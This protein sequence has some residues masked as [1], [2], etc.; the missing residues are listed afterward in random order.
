MIPEA[1]QENNWIATQYLDSGHHLLDSIWILMYPVPSTHSINVWYN[2]SIDLFA[3][4]GHIAVSLL[5]K[6]YTT[7]QTLH[8]MSHSAYCNVSFCKKSIWQQ[9]KTHHHYYINCLL[10]AITNIMIRRCCDCSLIHK[11]RHYTYWVDG[12]HPQSNCTKQSWFKTD[13]YFV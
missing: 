4:I 8:W 13:K 9:F 11:R 6:P 1:H 5:I 3:V 10:L 12:L 2:V 7:I